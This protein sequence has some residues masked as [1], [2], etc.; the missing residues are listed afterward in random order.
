LAKNNIK[1]TAVPTDI[2]MK[3]TKLVVKQIE[4]QNISAV[5]DQMSK[6]GLPV[7]ILKSG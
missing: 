6:L 7:K 2:K 4:Q 1:V 3:G 5:Q